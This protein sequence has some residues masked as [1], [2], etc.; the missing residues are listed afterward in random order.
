MFYNY[1]V[2][3][4][5]WSNELT[6]KLKELRHG[7]CIIISIRVNLLHP[8]PSLFLKL[9]GLFMISTFFAGDLCL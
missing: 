9:L 3:S 2:L 8:S 4:K 6:L 5:N 1:E 7:L